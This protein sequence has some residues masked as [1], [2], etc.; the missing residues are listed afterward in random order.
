M[1]AAGFW[2]A[3]AERAAKTFAQALLAVLGAGATGVL[4][5][6]WLGSLSA[7]AMAAVLSVLS[8]VASAGSG[9]DSG[10]SLGGEHVD[11]G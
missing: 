7:A 3:A 6:P 1:F 10:P 9:G 5:A 11:K 4:D 2:K 8:S